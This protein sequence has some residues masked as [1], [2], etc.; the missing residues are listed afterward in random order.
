[1]STSAKYSKR[2]Q[3]GIEHTSQPKPAHVSLKR[4]KLDY[5]EVNNRNENKLER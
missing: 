3:K 1:M 5:Y 4:I 2:R